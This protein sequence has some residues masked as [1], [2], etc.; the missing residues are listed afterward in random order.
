ME[1]LDSRIRVGILACFGGFATGF[2]SCA[3]INAMRKERN[4]EMVTSSRKFG[5]LIFSD[6]GGIGKETTVLSDIT[7]LVGSVSDSQVMIIIITKIFN[8][9]FVVLSQCR[10][11]EANAI[12]GQWGLLP[13]KRHLANNYKCKIIIIKVLQRGKSN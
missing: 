1:N 10:K 7:A 9:L 6:G 8:R 3:L 5:E 11:Q 4:E 12:S 2:A 13:P